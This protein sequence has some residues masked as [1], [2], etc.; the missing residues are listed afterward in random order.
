MGTA[1]LI[2]SDVQTAY[3][4][5]KFFSEDLVPTLV[6]PT[7]PLPEYFTADNSRPPTPNFADY[8]L[9]ADGIT[10]YEPKSSFYSSCKRFIQNNDTLSDKL[11]ELEL[12]KF[13]HP[14]LDLK[15]EVKI[16]F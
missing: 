6:Q 2:S 10:I 7:I 13:Q 11:K 1:S 5:G 15:F 8:Q 3:L 9:R 14:N 4:S 16:R 12:K